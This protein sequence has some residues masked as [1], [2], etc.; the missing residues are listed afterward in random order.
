VALAAAITP[1]WL[2]PFL[3]AESLGADAAGADADAAGAD[4]DA[5]DA[6]A[7]A[8][9]DPAAPSSRGGARRT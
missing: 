8:D 6:D 2:T 5:A 3:D 7:D 9:A 1:E 4:A